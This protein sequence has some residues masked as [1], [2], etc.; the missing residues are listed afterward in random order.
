MGDSVP[1]W[2]EGAKHGDQNAMKALW[3]R[4]HQ[5]LLRFARGKLPRNRRRVADE[6][7][8]VSQALK[9]FFCAAQEGR[10]PELREEDGLW[11]LL[12]KMTARKA[13]DLKRHE[14]RKKRYV[15]GESVL[16]PSPE[17]GQT[18]GMAQVAGGE[19]PPE[20]AAM[21][22]DELDRLL[23]LLGDPELVKV[24]IA[25]IEGL[26]N[27]EIADRFDTSLRTVERQLQLIRKKWE[28]LL[29]PKDE[30]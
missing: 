8:V 3:E 28:S 20:A 1:R 2:I 12:R 9:S 4:Y 17:E 18:D 26:Q 7:D 19:P 6:E 10:F 24:A 25:K 29:A 27:Q 5:R 15:L 30:G 22:S 16:I 11:R 14:G 13:V 21:E 23:D